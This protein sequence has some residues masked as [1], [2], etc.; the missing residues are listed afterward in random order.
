MIKKQTPDT[1]SINKSYFKSTL[2]LK[3]TL[4]KQK[5]EARGLKVSADS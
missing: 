5:Q 4:F 1:P 3:T 2:E